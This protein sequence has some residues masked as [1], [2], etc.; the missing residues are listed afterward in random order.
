MSAFAKGQSH[1][2]EYPFSRDQ[3]DEYDGEEVVTAP[4]WRP[5]VMFDT[6]NYGNTE[7]FAD[8]LGA[9]V[10]R[11]VDVFKPGHYPERVF[12][13]RQWRDPDGK[14]FGKPKL[15]ITT[16]QN[17]KVLLRGYRHPFDLPEEE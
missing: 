10:L 4:T 12:Y 5:G 2:V 6:D 7:T 3:Y 1:V 15:R 8:A 16:A 9:M 13:T 11:V 17:F 14:L